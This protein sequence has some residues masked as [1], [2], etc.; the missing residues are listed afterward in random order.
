MPTT[1]KAC[2]KSAE[3]NSG[4]GGEGGGAASFA[5]FSFR[6]NPQCSIGLRYKHPLEWTCSWDSASR[7]ATVKRPTGSSISFRAAAGSADAPV[8]GG[9]RKLNY[10]VRLLNQD[11]SPCT[12]GNPIYLDMVQSNGSTLRFSASTGKV[13]SLISS[14]GVETT[15]EAYAAKLQVNRHPSTGAIQSIWSQSQ[16][17]LQ[18][19]PEGNKLTL[20]WYSPSQVNKTA[21]SV[22]ASGTPY[23]TVSYENTLKDGAPVMLITEQRQ[24]MAAF[25]TER[26]VEGNNVTITQGEGDERIVRRIE[27]NFAARGQ[28]GDD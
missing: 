17:L 11:K 25:H 4:G 10:R 27:R 13:V 23:K 19:V 5:T 20:E 8:S 3:E 1:V 15:A 24:G 21:R 18:A 16:G 12:D 9:S 26:K 28:V 14:S 22:T 6:A 2:W 7:Q